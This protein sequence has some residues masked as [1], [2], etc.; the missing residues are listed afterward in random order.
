MGK[1]ILQNYYG[2]VATPELPRE[3]HLDAD[4]VRI[5]AHPLRSRLLTVLRMHGPS[6]ATELARR[7][8]TNSG[9][10]SYHLRKLAE[11]GLI[12]DT[13]TGEGPAP[14]RRERRWRSTSRRHSWRPVEEGDDNDAAAAAG[15]LDRDYLRHFAER[16]ERWLDLRDQWPTEWADE[17][18]LSDDFALVDLDQLRRLRAEIEA[19]LAKYVRVGQGNPGARRIAV[20]T[21]LYP[22][23]V[24]RPPSRTAPGT[25]RSGRGP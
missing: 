5:L 17:L 19:V 7:L 9:A 2:V 20:Y 12:D 23:D 21:Y 15:W 8:G 14:N 24:D 4:G 22:I 3:V 1:L 18:G 11:V 13:P 25:D 6:T 16:A 10:T